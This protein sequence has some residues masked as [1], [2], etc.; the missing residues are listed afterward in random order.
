MIGLCPNCSIKLKE[1][2]FN[3]RETNEVM[4][5]LLYRKLVESGKKLKNIAE[6]GY[7]EIC[8]ATLEDLKEQRKL[9]KVIV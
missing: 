6:F 1:P 3:N 4:I 9:M 8:K 7:C 5:T 2:P